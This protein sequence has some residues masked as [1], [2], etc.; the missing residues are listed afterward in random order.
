[1]PELTSS[2]GCPGVS[3]TGYNGTQGI[4]SG[5]QGGYNG[6]QGVYDGTLGGYNGGY[7]NTDTKSQ[8]I[9]GGGQPIAEV[10]TPGDGP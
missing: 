5:A 9:S 4:Y 3:Q 1:M 6:T 7:G 2:N 10:Y 8:H